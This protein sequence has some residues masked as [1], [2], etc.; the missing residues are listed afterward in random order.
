MLTRLAS[1]CDSYIG[2]DFS[3]EGLT[4]LHAY[5]AHRPDLCHVRLRQ[6]AAHD[7]AFLADNSL[8]LVI[9]NS[10]VQ[11]FPEPDRSGAIGAV[12]R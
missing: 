8:D 12:S 2:L 9:L 3:A 1:S 4:Q 10:V 5:L 7:L 11:Y 6:A